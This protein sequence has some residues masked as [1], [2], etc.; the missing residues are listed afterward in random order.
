MEQVTSDSDTKI[1]THGSAKLANSGAKYDWS[2]LNRKDEVHPARVP[3]A[4]PHVQLQS[5]AIPEEVQ[6]WLRT[7]HGPHRGHL[8]YDATI[9][10]LFR[11]AGFRRVALRGQVP[12]D[13]EML[14]NIGSSRVMSVRRCR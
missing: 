8:G 2:T 10:N 11:I 1:K 13:M 14:L 9:D 3:D 7:A 5:P 12:S 4:Y 6:E